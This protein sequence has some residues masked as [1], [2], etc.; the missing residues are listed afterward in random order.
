M[1]REP[2]HAA[3]GELT[4]H[5]SPPSRTVRR[6]IFLQFSFLTA[7]CTVQP[8]SRQPLI[9]LRRCIL[10]QDRISW[11]CPLPFLSLSWRRLSVPNLWTNSDASFAVQTLIS[12]C[13]PLKLRSSDTIAILPILS[14]KSTRNLFIFTAPL[15]RYLKKFPEVYN[16]AIICFNSIS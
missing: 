3:T 7:Q 4:G 1:Y 11:I 9:E 12:T 6:K 5:R 8:S 14:A 13:P 10:S 15:L 16:M 2:Y